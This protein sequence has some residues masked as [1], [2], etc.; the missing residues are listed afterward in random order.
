MN[1]SVN[2]LNKLSNYIKIT[3][4]GNQPCIE[5]GS[6]ASDFKVLITNTDIK[7]MEGSSVPAS[8]SNEFLNIGK[9]NIKDELKQGGFVWRARGENGNG[10]LGLIWKGSDT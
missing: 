4:D 10:N 2:D 5:L 6:D 3:T 9:A 1:D 7:F 8:I